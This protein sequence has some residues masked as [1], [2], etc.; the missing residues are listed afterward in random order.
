[1]PQSPVDARV[2]YVLGHAIKLIIR[3]DRL[4]ALAL[5]L[6][7]I[8]TKSRDA[9]KPAP[10][11]HGSARKYQSKHSKQKAARPKGR[12]KLKTAARLLQPILRKKIKTKNE[13]A[14]KQKKQNPK[15]NKLIK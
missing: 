6:R 2:N 10:N 12:E 5:V 15:P 9:K 13:N 1:M 7:A 4:D 14:L 8:V 3:R 11:R